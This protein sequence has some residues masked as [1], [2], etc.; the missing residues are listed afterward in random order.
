MTAFLHKDDVRRFSLSLPKDIQSAYH[1]IVDPVKGVAPTS[2]RIVEDVEMLKFSMVKIMNAE[3]GVVRGLASRPGRRAF[4]DYRR[5]NADE[6]V[7]AMKGK[8]TLKWTHHEDAKSAM[9]ELFQRVVARNGGNAT[10]GV[11][12]KQNQP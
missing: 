12:K 8:K 6:D 7:V 4:T 2:E 3:G 1:R 9:E 10:M 11:Y 5:E